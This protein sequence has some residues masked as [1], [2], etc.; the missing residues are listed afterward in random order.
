MHE[1]REAEEPALEVLLAKLAPVDLVLVEG[2]KQEPFAKIEAALSP[3]KRPLLAL[4][5]PYIK[6][7]AAGYQPKGLQTP[8]FDIN[9]IPAIAD[10]IL[11]QTG[12]LP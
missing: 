11:W 1:L 6:A 2:Y 4:E 5:T 7:V 9:D 3:G 10:F 12:L 8:V